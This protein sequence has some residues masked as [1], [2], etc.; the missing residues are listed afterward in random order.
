MENIQLSQTEQIVLTSIAS[1]VLFLLDCN[2]S[3]VNLP[4]DLSSAILVMFTLFCLNKVH[5]R[6]VTPRK[7]LASLPLNIVLIYLANQVILLLIWNPVCF[8]L[9]YF[10]E[11]LLWYMQ[12]MSPASYAHY[13]YHFSYI[14]RLLSV[15]LLTVATYKAYFMPEQRLL[16]WLERPRRRRNRR[17]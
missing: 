4:R 8:F 12:P 6:L 14:V 9:E 1:L 7:S 3:K 16:W 10:K 11:S 5:L 15:I 17:I 13:S 2:L